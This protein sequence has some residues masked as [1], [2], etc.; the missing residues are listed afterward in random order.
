MTIGVLYIC[1]GKYTIFWESFYQSAEKYLLPGYEKH[2]FVFTDNES[3][4]DTH[5]NPFVHFVHQEKLG[6]PYDTLYRFK[7]FLK[8]ENELTT[9]DYLFFFNANLVIQTPITAEELLPN[10]QEE[11]TVVQHPGFFSKSRE[12]FTYDV[13]EKSKAY[14]APEKGNIYIAGGLNGGKSSN[15]LQMIRTLSANIDID[16]NKGIIALWHDESHINSYIL[17]KEVKVLSP[18]Y[19]YPE[20]WDIPFEQKILILDKKRFGGHKFLRQSSSK[21]LSFL[22]KIFSRKK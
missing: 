4:I 21:G 10:E 16:H 20:N 11:L 7:M 8:I 18:A 14:I 6:W 1:T 17:D 9:M 15:Y 5:Q 12:E 2:Y 13:Q 22:A 3:E 19:L